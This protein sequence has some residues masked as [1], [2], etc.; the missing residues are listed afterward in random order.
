MAEAQSRLNRVQPAPGHSSR[1]AMIGGAVRALAYAALW[2]V[3]E[4]DSQL[5]ADL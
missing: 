4:Y 2:F 1:L 5:Q 3:A